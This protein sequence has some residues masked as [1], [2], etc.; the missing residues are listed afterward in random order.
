MAQPAR[1][2]YDDSKENPQRSSSAN[3]NSR[4]IAS[5]TNGAAQ[6][7]GRRLSKSDKK[8]MRDR[9]SAPS[10]LER[11]VNVKKYYDDDEYDALTQKQQNYNAQI[12]LSGENRSA[13]RP[14]SM[15]ERIRS[16][17]RKGGGAKGGKGGVIAQAMRVDAARR[18]MKNEEE[19]EDEMAPEQMRSPQSLPNSGTG[20]GLRSRFTPGMKAAQQKFG[21]DY[22]ARIKAVRIVMRLANPLFWVWFAQSIFACLSLVGLGAAALYDQSWAAAIVNIFANAAL[23]VQTD[24]SSLFMVPWMLAWV[25]GFIS[26]MIVFVF[27]LISGLSPLNGKG[28][29]VKYTAFIGVLWLYGVPIVNVFPLVAFYALALVAYPK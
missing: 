22:K 10:R 19:S 27:F 12:I 3:R 28:A 17:G 20:P 16:A 23:G 25:L 24:G 5:G 13:A 2:F 18:Y 8:R 26:M 9:Q 11:V 29:W 14:P 21:G 4:F 15:S 1:Q 7:G 6:V